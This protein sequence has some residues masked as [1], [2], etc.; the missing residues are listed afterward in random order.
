MMPLC[1]RTEMGIAKLERVED[2]AV[3]GKFAGEIVWNVAHRD[4]FCDGN[5]PSEGHIPPIEARAHCPESNLHLD[6]RTSPSASSRCSWV[7]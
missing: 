3:I 4:S 2:S 5:A 1:Q 7:A 6:G